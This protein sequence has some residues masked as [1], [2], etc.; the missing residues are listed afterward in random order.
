M[1]SQSLRDTSHQAEFIVT[2][3]NSGI[4]IIVVSETWF[5]TNDQAF[6]LPGYK[7]YCANRIDRVG[8]GVAVF[9]KSNLSV[10]V[11]SA[12]NGEYAKPDYILLDILVES[13]KILFAAMYRRP[14]QGYV[15][16]F[17]ED[18]Y[19]FSP[20]YKYSF[21]C[22][23]LNAGFGR[24]GEDAQVVPELLNLCNLQNV[25]FQATYHTVNCDSVLDVICSN[26]SELLLKY[27]QTFAPGFSAHDLIFAVFDLS[28]PRY[29]KQK[30]TL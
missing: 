2:F 17:L 21:L 15:N 8:G 14:K 30:N 16:F 5:K 29:S 19:T 22:G 24:G 11:L 27:G 10:K 3:T 4:D 6:N 12:S 28:V 1:N 7:V 23:D 20:N 18:F 26:C 13:T 25:P 9:V